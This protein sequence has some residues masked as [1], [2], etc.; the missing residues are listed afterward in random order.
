MCSKMTDRMIKI[1]SEINQEVVI[2]QYAFDYSYIIRL[3]TE[4]Y[5]IDE[6]SKC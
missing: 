4:K 3:F 2:F 1:S 6:N 5:S